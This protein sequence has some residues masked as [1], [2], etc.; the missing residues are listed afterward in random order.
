MGDGDPEVDDE[1]EDDD[2]NLDLTPA[3]VRST[4]PPRW[5]F[6]KTGNSPTHHE[7]RHTIHDSYTFRRGGSRTDVD[8]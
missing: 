6:S 2:D 4:P 5:S 3:S 8:S 7:P 1:E